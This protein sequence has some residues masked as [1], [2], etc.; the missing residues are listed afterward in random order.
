M[1]NKS[2]YLILSVCNFGVFLVVAGLHNAL[3]V[4]ILFA[5]ILINHYLLISGVKAMVKSEKKSAFLVL[6][7]F[8]IIPVFLYAMSAMPDHVALCAAVFTF[9]LIILTL[10]IKRDNKKN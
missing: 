10:S 8:V 3:P 1:I 4:T 2:T 5:G 7:F 6:K 9:Q